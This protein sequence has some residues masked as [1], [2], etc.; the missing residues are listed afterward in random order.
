MWIDLNGLQ[1]CYSL[2]QRI[3]CYNGQI[4]PEE[5]QLISGGNQIIGGPLGILPIPDLACFSTCVVKAFLPDFIIGVGEGFASGAAHQ[6][7]KGGSYIALLYSLS[8][9]IHC[10]E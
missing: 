10:F 5:S 8:H 3:E 4:S 9:A 6:L 1:R 2:G 7:I